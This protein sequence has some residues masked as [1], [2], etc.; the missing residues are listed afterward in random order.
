MRRSKVWPRV[1]DMFSIALVYLY[2]KTGL[3]PQRSRNVGWI[4]LGGGYAL[5]NAGGSGVLWRHRRTTL[6]A[7]DAASS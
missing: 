3:A 2:G 6:L 5:F 7:L 4:H 1:F